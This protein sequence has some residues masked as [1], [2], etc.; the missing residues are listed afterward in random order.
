MGIVYKFK[1]DDL[2][3]LE[4]IGYTILPEQDAAIKFFNCPPDS[5]LVMYSL[6]NFYENK[7]WKNKIYKP[8]KKFFQKNMGLY[9]DR[10]GNIKQNEK[11]NE[12]L[13]TW[14]IQIEKDEYCWVGVTSCDEN[15]KHVFYG[16]KVLDSYFEPEIIKLK[17]HDL[18]EEV[19]IEE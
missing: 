3:K 1:C 19:Q 5:G 7:E 9:Y 16:K 2:T 18:I 15:D 6:N 12:I 8:N 10:N 17:W 4:E 13:T 14:I 11:F